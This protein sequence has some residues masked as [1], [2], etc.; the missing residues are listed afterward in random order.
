[1][2][3]PGMV[4]EWRTGDVTVGEFARSPAWVEE[5]DPSFLE[6][7]PGVL[8]ARR[9]GGGRLVLELAEGCDPQPLL[10]EA[11]ALLRLARFERVQ[12]SL[13]EIFVERVTAAGG[14]A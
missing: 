6:S 3:T 1:M 9:E 12:P 13:H 4:G 10:R 5:G 11:A 2:M 14:T 7:W 8:A